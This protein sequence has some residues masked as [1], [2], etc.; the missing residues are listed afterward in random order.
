MSSS[1]DRARNTPIA[2]SPSD[3]VPTGPLAKLN[4][5]FCEFPLGRTRVRSNPSSVRPSSS[6]APSTAT[7]SVPSSERNGSA[8]FG[9]LLPLFSTA[10]VLVAGL[11]TGGGGAGGGAKLAC[12]TA[13][14]GAVC[15][16]DKPSTGA[17]VVVALPAAGSATAATGLG[18]FSFAGASSTGTP[19]RHSPS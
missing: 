13:G 19:P 5:I 1:L 4:A 14:W 6:V 10:A 16:V 17:R 18:E 2:L 11:A 15:A 12:L 9:A 8:G 7:S 3:T